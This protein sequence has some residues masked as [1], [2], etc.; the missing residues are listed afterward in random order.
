MILLQEWK[1]KSQM[2]RKHYQ[3]RACI[4]NWE[5]SSINNK[6]MNNPIKKRK[7]QWS[8]HFTKDVQMAYKHMKGGC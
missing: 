1:G 4:Q 3:L 8:E 6:T 5:F 2:G 7:E